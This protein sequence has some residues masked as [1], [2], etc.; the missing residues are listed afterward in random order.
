MTRHPTAPQRLAAARLALA[1]ALAPST[2]ETWKGLVRAGGTKPTYLGSPAAGAAAP[3]SGT[4]GKP[5][6]VS[7]EPATGSVH[8]LPSR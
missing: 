8:S 6:S 5:L 3:A 4:V 1:L 2:M 7:A